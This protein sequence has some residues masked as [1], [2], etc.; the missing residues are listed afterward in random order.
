MAI[1]MAEVARAHLPAGNVHGQPPSNGMTSKHFRARGGTRFRLMDPPSS[2][3]FRIAR[4]PFVSPPWQYAI[5]ELLPKT[6]GGRFDD[7]SGRWCVPDEQRFR[8]LY[9]TTQRTGEFAET[10]DAFRVKLPELMQ[11]VRNFVTDIDGDEA[12][13]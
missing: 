7:P 13:Q 2:V 4:D 11:R 6:F 9:C 3:V 5:N 10:T 1:R 8:T 12:F